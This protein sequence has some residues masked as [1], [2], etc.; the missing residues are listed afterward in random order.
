[1]DINENKKENLV[2]QK[3]IPKLA[4]VATGTVS[5]FDKIMKC[6]DEELIQKVRNGKMS[7]H[8]YP[9]EI[10]IVRTL[11]NFNYMMYFSIVERS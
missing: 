7:I 6:D 11:D 5:R 8:V 3:E 2:T 10:S 9:L 4:G 1:M